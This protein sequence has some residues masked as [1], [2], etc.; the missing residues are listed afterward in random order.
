MVTNTA[1][2]SSEEQAV[3]L[4]GLRTEVRCSFEGYKDL[5]KNE[6]EQIFEYS[7]QSTGEQNDHLL[8]VEQRLRELEERLYG[9]AVEQRL[10]ELKSTPD[11]PKRKSDPLRV[12][13]DGKWSMYQMEP[14]RGINR[15]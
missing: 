1:E 8:Q 6:S 9:R 7:A 12:P 11:L 5:L 4:E 2:S 15:P 3:Q 13:P 14:I 10:R